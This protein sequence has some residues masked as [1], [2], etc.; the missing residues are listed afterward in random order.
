MSFAEGIWIYNNCNTDFQSN[1]DYYGSH[2][3]W[4]TGASSRQQAGMIVAGSD[5]DWPTYQCVEIETWYV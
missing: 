4:P 3:E 1:V 5:K 2:Y